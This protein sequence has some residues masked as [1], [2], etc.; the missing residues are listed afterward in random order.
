[1]KSKKSRT[2]DTGEKPRRSAGRP[3][4]QGGT[5]TEGDSE[6]SAH[7]EADSNRRPSPELST[8]HPAPAPTPI[9]IA[10]KV[11][12]FEGAQE[13]ERKFITILVTDIADYS[14]ISKNLPSEEQYRVMAQCHQMFCD[15]VARYGGMMTQTR[16]GT[17][18]AVFGAPFAYEDHGRRACEAAL[19]ISTE[20]AHYSKKLR[21]EEG[22][23][24]QTRIGLVSGVVLSGSLSSKEDINYEDLDDL[25]DMVPKVRTFMKPGTVVVARSTYELVRDLFEF[26][27]LRERREPVDSQDVET[28]EL[29]KAAPILGPIESRQVRGLS[30]FVGREEELSTLLKISEKARKGF[31]QALGIV[32]AAGVG[33]SRLVFELKKAVSPGQQ[34]WLEGYCRSYNGVPPYHPFL[35]VLKSV[36]A[37]KPGDKEISAKKKIKKRLPGIAGASEEILAPLHEIMAL[38]DEDERYLGLTFKEKRNRIFKAVETVLVGEAQ[39]KP[40]VVILEDLHW[41]DRTSEELLAYLIE[42]IHGTNVLLLLLYR[43]EYE[44]SSRLG[45]GLSEIRLGEL[46]ERP[47]RMLA[48]TVL[49]DSVVDAGLMDLIR[50][51]TG[52]NPLFIEEFTMSLL[53]SGAL[54][55][56]DGK[57]LLKSKSPTEL[58]PKGIQGVISARMDRLLPEVKTTLQ[59]ASVIGREVP[60]RLL[61]RVRKADYDIESHFLELQRFEFLT[62]KV[63]SAEREFLFKHALTR[64]SAYQGMLHQKRNLIHDDVGHAMEEVFPERLDDFYEQLA[65]HFS[66]AGNHEKAFN[67]LKLSALKAQRKN[68]PW[69]AYEYAKEA[70]RSIKEIQASSKK[71]E[72]EI[73]VL[74]IL[75]QV[76]RMLDYA[77]KD[78]E[79]IMKR[80]EALCLQVAHE[81]GL[82]SFRA[83]LCI[84]YMAIGDGNNCRKYSEYLSKE[85]QTLGHLG[86]TKGQLKIMVPIA[87]E[88]SM[89]GLLGRFWETLPVNLSVLKSMEEAQAVVE[90]YNMPFRAYPFIAGQSGVFSAVLGDF[91]TAMVL[92]EKALDVALRTEDIPTVSMTEFFY[93]VVLNHRGQGGESVVFLE[94]AIMRWKE[95]GSGAVW[96]TTVAANQRA[97]LGYAYFLAGNL[98]AA[99]RQIEAAIKMQHDSGIVYYLSHSYAILGMVHLAT[100]DLGS[101]QSC[102]ESALE[103]S[104]KTGEKHWKGFSRILQGRILGESQLLQASKAESFI[105][106]GIDILNEFRMRP[107]CAQGYLYLGELYAGTGRTQL[108]AK[109]LKRAHKMFKEMGMDYWLRKTEAALSRFQRTE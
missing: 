68:S 11:L 66:R 81:S 88:H 67:Y 82:A 59:V 55:K 64:E 94:R 52:G 28:Y 89:A 60:L 36:F 21:E 9:F 86:L 57:I 1:M 73:E 95:V 13:D 105:I 39:G 5:T 32:G 76:M 96:G 46:P 79:E 51:H 92:C 19:S 85:I 22:V 20:F 23:E 17:A 31:G 108:A 2:G 75:N 84:Y 44:G 90:E 30:K 42:R 74:V 16:G 71:R 43:P 107:Y 12:A 48:E 8:R 106:E 24:L 34:T 49:G 4:L 56:V 109:N 35:D 78:S 54:D 40:L 87:F 27:A 97:A 58:V 102:I 61:E 98:E 47:M 14:S 50:R 15:Q 91:H 80:G 25:D 77:P 33:K 103:L 93:A 104:E 65:H 38:T 6:S 99:Q 101:A 29:L 41:I 26:R 70:I 63:P 3:R 53:Q 7:G 10:D 45:S 69:E 72:L 100:R 62:E 18:K 37:I 83:H